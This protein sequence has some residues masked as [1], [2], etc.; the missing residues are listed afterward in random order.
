M[1][2]ARVVDLEVLEDFSASARCDEGFLQ[3]RRLRVRNRRADGSTSPIYRVDVVDRP[4]LDAVAVLVFRRNAQGAHEFLTRQNLRPAAHFRKDKH[5][6]VPDGRSHLFCEEIVAGLFEA[7]DEGEAGVRAR[8]AAEVFEEAGYRVEP[9]SVVLL[10]P[11]FFVAPGIVS[12][13]IFLTAVDVTGLSAQAPEGDGS[14]L[15]E[16]GDPTWHSQAQL[17][18]AID[19]GRVQDAKTELAL[20]RFLTRP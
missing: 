13:K 10:G 8:A 17:L 7:A 1:T 4:R 6:T 20:R 2:L 5:P 12:E 9:A 19:S 18:A 16:G 14:P 3:I 15:E 11:P